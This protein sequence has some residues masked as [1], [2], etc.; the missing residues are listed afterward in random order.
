VWVSVVI[1]V[2]LRAVFLPPAGRFGHVFD[3][4]DDVDAT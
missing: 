3:V 1:D 2:Y 4:V